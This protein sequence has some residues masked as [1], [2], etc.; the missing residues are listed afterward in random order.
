ME[1]DHTSRALIPRGLEMDPRPEFVFLA[2]EAGSLELFSHATGRALHVPLP[3]LPAEGE[4]VALP[5]PQGW[6]TLPAGLARWTVPGPAGEPRQSA[7]FEVLPQ[8]ERRNINDELTA[9]VQELPPPAR[10]FMRGHY[11]LRYGLYVRASHQFAALARQFP[12]QEHPR[13]MLA[14]IGQALGVDSEI[15]L[16]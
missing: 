7:T 8:T 9:H 15:F 14:G 5:Y 6:P 13:R 4:L 2:G 11:F 3:D 16:R 12:G 10:A 1:V